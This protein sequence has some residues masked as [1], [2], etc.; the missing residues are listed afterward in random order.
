MATTRVFGQIQMDQRPRTF[1]TR[2][3]SNGF[4]SEALGRVGD[5]RNEVSFPSLGGTSGHCLYEVRF[6]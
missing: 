2:L 6:L 4:R 5:Y 3:Y 1:G